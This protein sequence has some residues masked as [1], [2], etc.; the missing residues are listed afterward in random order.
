MKRI[1]VTGTGSSVGKTHLTCALARSFAAQKLRVAAFKPI[2]TGIEPAGGDYTDSGQLAAVSAFHVKRWLDPVY[3]FREPLSPHLAARRAG[4]SLELQPVLDALRLFDGLD[5]NMVLVELAGGLFSPL[6]SKETNADLALA[7]HHAAVRASAT[8]ALQA[9]PLTQQIAV[10]AQ[11]GAAGSPAAVIDAPGTTSGTWSSS[12]AVSSDSFPATSW[13]R[14]D[15]FPPGETPA[16]GPAT[17]DDSLPRILL[18]APD[19]SGVLH[20]IAATTRAA[21]ALGL[22]LTGITLVMPEHPD[23]ST[24]LNGPEIGYVTSV[25]Y[26]GTLRRAPIDVLANDLKLSGFLNRLF[27]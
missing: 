27:A 5:L 7:I 16:S 10:T 25:P 20:E 15:S 23:A 2:D 6:N 17:Q 21:E 22:P 9:A 8:A 14:A 11:S 12:A 18:V 4:I 24:G 19:R 13:S 26:L 1:V 3:I